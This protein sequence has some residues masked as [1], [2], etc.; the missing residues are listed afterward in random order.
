[1]RSKKT[2][3][4]LRADNQQSLRQ[5]SKIFATFLCTREAF[6]L[7][8]TVTSRENVRHIFQL[9]GEPKTLTQLKTNCCLSCYQQKRE[10]KCMQLFL[11][12]HQL[13]LHNN[14]QFFLSKTRIGIFSY[15]IYQ[16]FLV[17]SVPDFVFYRRKQQEE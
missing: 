6:V 16:N 4:L 2:G 12:G 11:H 14:H 17:F 5:K 3:G 10:I 8:Y 1:M 15:L 13:F 9:L 7:S